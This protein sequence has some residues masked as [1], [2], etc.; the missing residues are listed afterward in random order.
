VSELEQGKSIVDAC[1]QA[2]V[3]QFIYG[4]LP[5]AKKIS[6]GKWEVA[7]FTE[8]AQ[9]EDYAKKAGF[10]YTGF[11]CPPFYYENFLSFFFAPVQKGGEW[12]FNFPDTKH[13]TAASI[14][15]IGKVVCCMLNHPGEM[16]GVFVPIIAEQGS[17]EYFVK[18]FAAALGVKARANL[19]PIESMKKDNKEFYEM[20]SYFNEFDYYGPH[21]DKSTQLRALPHQLKFRDWVRQQGLDAF[22]QKKDALVEAD[23]KR[24]ASHT[25]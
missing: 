9:V 25:Q 21:V 10:R 14:S 11:P 4:A 3:E 18:E 7:H 2:N 12:V 23:S 20:F 13:L 5:N 8:K 24:D 6:G 16:N 22:S 15:E 17:P 19:Y 1:K